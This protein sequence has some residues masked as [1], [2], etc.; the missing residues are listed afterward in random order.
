[1]GEGV[2]QQVCIGLCKE[3]AQFCTGGTYCRDSETHREDRSPGF[4]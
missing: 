4:D 1:M 3:R 2:T